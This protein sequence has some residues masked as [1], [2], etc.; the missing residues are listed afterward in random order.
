MESLVGL[1]EAK[2]AD[3]V[4]ADPL[5]AVAFNRLA[6]WILGRAIVEAQLDEAVGIAVS[7]DTA[8]RSDDDP[9]TDL[10]EALPGGGLFGGLA[11]FAL[12]PGEFPVPTIDGALGTLTDQVAIPAPDH[13]DP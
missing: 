5:D 9:Q 11:R 2:S 8:E 13:P 12:S 4:G 1:R 6:I 7:G 3:P 10:L